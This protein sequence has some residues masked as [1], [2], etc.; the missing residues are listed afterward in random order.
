MCF[1]TEKNA[2]VEMQPDNENTRQF[3]VNL[4]V[5]QALSN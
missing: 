3:Q 4:R 2:E 5:F 1:E